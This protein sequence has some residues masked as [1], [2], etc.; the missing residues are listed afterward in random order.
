M[1][2]TILDV[3]KWQGRIDWD[4]VK[5]SGLISGV[6]IRAMGNSKEGKPS[7]PYLDP[8][9]ARNYA[10]CTRLG[11]PVGVYG[12]FKATTKAQAD[13]ELALFKQALGGRT[14]QLPVAV[15]IED[16][17]QAA[18][19]KSALTDI[20]AHCLSVVESWGVY[21][22]LYTGLNFGQTNLYMGGAALKPYD[23]WLA[24]Y[25]TKKPA[26]GWA[27]GMWQYTSSG[28]VPGI[29]KGADLSVA[30]KDYA[31]IIQQA[32]LGQTDGDDSGRCDHR[33]R[34]AD[35]CADCQQQDAG[36]DRDQAG[37]ADPGGAVAQQLRPA[38]AGDRG[39]AES[40]KPPHCRSGRT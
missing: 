28:K 16:K 24:A 19:S 30:Y 25:R 29:A 5:T 40:G 39:A 37:G 34:D 9:F 15:D 11:I 17:L 22:M 27:F 31:A 6:M 26:P 21:A 8:F 33:R 18:L 10:E 20:V 38:G 7:K 23:V 4:K 1:P 13:K 36:C 12:Y 32:G 2:R 14:F 3:S 35:R